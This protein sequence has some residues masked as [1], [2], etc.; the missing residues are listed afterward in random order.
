MPDNTRA[1]LQRQNWSPGEPQPSAWTG[2]KAAEDQVLPVTTL[3]CPKCAYLELYAAPQSQD[4]VV[5]SRRVSSL[6]WS[7]AAIGLAFL[8]PA[9]GLFFSNSGQMIFT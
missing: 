2:L 7:L 6:R 4:G 8:L 3:R 1:G 9:L 5:P